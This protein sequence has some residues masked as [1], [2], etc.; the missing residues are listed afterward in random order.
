MFPTL[1]RDRVKS[2]Q[3]SADDFEDAKERQ[4]NKCGQPQK[5]GM[6]PQCIEARKQKYESWSSDYKELDFTNKL[7]KW[8]VN[9]P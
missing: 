8:E 7:N 3:S 9:L 4:G 6:I 2:T 5:L 1:V